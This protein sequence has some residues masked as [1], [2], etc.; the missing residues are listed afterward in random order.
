MKLKQFDLAKR[1]TREIDDFLD[2][3]LIEVKK[4]LIF[5][6]DNDWLLVLYD[7]RGELLVREGQRLGQI[8]EVAHS[9]RADELYSELKNANQ[10][11]LYLLDKYHIPKSIALDVIDEVKVLEITEK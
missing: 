7:L 10:R 6:K 3:E 9:V 5:N 8:Q 4:I 2:D 1:D 11:C